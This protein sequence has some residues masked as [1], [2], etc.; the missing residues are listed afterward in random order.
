VLAALVP[1]ILFM[2]MQRVCGVPVVRAGTPL[3]ITA[4]FAASF[5]LNVVLN[6]VWIPRFGPV[7]A[8]LASSVSY[9]VAAA[10]FLAWTTQ[11]AGSLTY[12]LPVRS[13]ADVV[14]RAL[15]L[16]GGGSAIRTGAETAL[17][18]RPR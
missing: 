16:L 17:R 11:L 4:I 13:D 15:V 3:R 2:S 10:L 1:G 18:Q 9:A 5:V 6:L 8:S 7:G 12:L 14:R